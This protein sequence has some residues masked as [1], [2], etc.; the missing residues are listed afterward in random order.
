MDKRFS[1][2]NED[3]N[4]QYSEAVRNAYRCAVN[5]KKSVLG[6]KNY[7][8]TK[9]D[10][11]NLTRAQLEALAEVDKFLSGRDPLSAAEQRW[12]KIRSNYRK[13]DLNMNGNIM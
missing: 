4:D 2:S 9:Y 7:K 12:K 11:L 5:Y 10:G 6:L 3:A 13:N 8:T 1:I